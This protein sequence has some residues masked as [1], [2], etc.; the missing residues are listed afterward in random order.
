MTPNGNALADGFG[1]AGSAHINGSL[2]PTAPPQSASSP[3]SP[4]TREP[5]PGVASYPPMTLEK[6]EGASAEVTA[7][8]GDSLQSLRLSMPMQETQLCKHKLMCSDCPPPH[9]SVYPQPTNHPPDPSNLISLCLFGSCPH[10]FFNP[11]VCE[12]S[13]PRDSVGF[14]LI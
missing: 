14:L 3:V 5:S 12:L 2:P 1:A 10:P 13:E 4:Q 7:H 11:L 9:P 6:S 8:K